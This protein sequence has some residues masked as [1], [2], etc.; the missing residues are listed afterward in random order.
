MIVNHKILLLAMFMT[1]FYSKEALT[2][3]STYSLKSYIIPS[4]NDNGVKAKQARDK[5]AEM[6]LA[7]NQAFDVLILNFQHINISS[8]TQ[9]LYD[10]TI[11]DKFE[12]FG[13]YH[14]TSY[15]AEASENSEM[16]LI[17]RRLL[18]L[19]KQA[20]LKTKVNDLPV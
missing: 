2:F 1:K 10:L 17:T 9:D 7:E 15:V 16:N 13:I 14:E 3:V 12:M 6:V 19:G 4:K 8:G 11:V 18:E 5:I 20:V